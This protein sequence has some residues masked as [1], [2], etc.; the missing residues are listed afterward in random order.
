MKRR[1]KKHYRMTMLILTIAISGCGK[2]TGGNE[3]KATG[4]PE[5]TATPEVIVTPEVIETPKP[6]EAIY[7][8]E[9]KDHVV[10]DSRHSQYPIISGWSLE[11]KMDEWNDYFLRTAISDIE[12]SGK[13]DEISYCVTVMEQTHDILSMKWSGYYFYE[14]APHPNNWERTL[15]IDMI[16]GKQLLLNDIADVNE[17]ASILLS[18]EGYTL[19]GCDDATMQDVWDYNFYG[20]IPKQE[21][22]AEV[23]SHFD[24]PYS[25]YGESTCFG[26][27]YIQDGKIVLNMMVPHAIGDYISIQID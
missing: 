11:D 22:L 12:G 27:S 2:S 18:G 7:R 13:N 16:T 3:I 8:V 1:M 4:T 26:S 9:I 6:V 21:E 17:I 20:E 25:E 23:L 19:I 10:S 15:T 14:D 24:G 5:V